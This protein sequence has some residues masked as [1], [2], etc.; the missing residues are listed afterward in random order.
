[1]TAEHNLVTLI[2]WDEG[3]KYGTNSDSLLGYWSV[4]WRGTVYYYY[5]AKGGRVS[6]KNQA[7]QSEVRPQYCR[8]ARLLVRIHRS[9]SISRGP[10]PAAGAIH[11]PD[12][13][14]RQRHGRHLERQRAAVATR[15]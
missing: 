4:L 15:L 5:F 13:V 9:V 11:P 1:M 7:G 2:H 8:G 6:Y 12:D 14:H 10:P 3:D